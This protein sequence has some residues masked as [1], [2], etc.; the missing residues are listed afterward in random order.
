M[1]AK[2][3]EESRK[4]FVETI[5]TINKMLLHTPEVQK[6]LQRLGEEQ[7]KREQDTRTRFL[8]YGD[9]NGYMSPEKVLVVLKCA[10]R[11]K[12]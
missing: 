7:L 6:L 11:Y 8:K 12:D 4:Q 9:V 1:K 3:L 10:R 5:N 2:C